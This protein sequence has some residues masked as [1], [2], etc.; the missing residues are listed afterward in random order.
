M[1]EARLSP[2][3]R[4]IIPVHPFGQP[5]DMDPIR[6]IARR[7]RLKLIED[8]CETLFARYQGRWVGSL[9][10][11]GCFSTYMAHLLVTGVGG[12][13]TT[14]DPEYAVC[15]RSL[16]NLGR[17]PAYLSIDDDDR[18]S[19]DALESVVARRFRIT[20]DPEWGKDGGGR[21][22]GYAPD[23]AQQG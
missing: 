20:M 16:I 9:G 15:L 22:L 7:H 4:A 2:R 23:G 6:E 3:T 14:N 18:V 8:S 21:G 17:D 10:D 13:N 5:A 12:I 1:V 19:A 11:I